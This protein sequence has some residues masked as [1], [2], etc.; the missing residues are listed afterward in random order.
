MG[1]RYQRDSPA[2]G[3]SYAP[4]VHA[5]EVEPHP[6][7]A[8]GAAGRFASDT[9]VEPLGEGRFAATIDPGWSVIDGAAPNGGYVMAVGARA[10]A[11]SAGMPDPISVT[12]HFLAP[13]SPGPVEVRTR[14]LRSGRRHVT[15]AAD[16]HEGDRI[17]TSLLGVFGDLAAVDGPTVDLRSGPPLPPVEDCPDGDSQ[18]PEAP[19]IFQ[20]FEHRPAPGVMGWATGQRTGDGAVGGWLK[21]ADGAPMDTLGLL[22]VADCY[23]PAV[24]NLDGLTVGWAPTIELT[25][26]VRARPAA[27]WL[28]GWF[29]T[30]SVTDGYLEEDG[31]VRDGTGRLVA[32]SRQLALVPRG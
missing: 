9:H 17:V 11:A 5:D 28:G 3:W 18:R 13:P 14:V 10:M 16:I 22:V 25:V 29:T 19:P 12:A 4:G 24:F 20:R 1:R 8:I 21:W 2:P 32:L 30:H 6:D 15:V 23:P 31:E 26:Q 7:D 27:G